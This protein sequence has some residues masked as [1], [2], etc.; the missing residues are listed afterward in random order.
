MSGSVTYMDIKTEIVGRI[1]RGDWP[2]DTI[3]PGEVELAAQLGCARATVN[4][5]LR[6]LADEGVVERRRKAGTR[7]VAGQNRSARID[8][9]V[10]RTQIEAA[11]AHYRYEL[12]KR[13]I[14]AARDP[15]RARLDLQSDQEVLSLECLHFAGD[16]PYQ[17]EVRW[18]NLAAVPAARDEPFEQI[19]PNEWLLRE[20]PLTDAEHVMSAG[21]ATKHQASALH[22]EE[23]DAVFIVERRTWLGAETIT[24]VR[25]VHVGATFQLRS[26]NLQQLETD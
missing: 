15:I 7:V 16:A 25:L 17:L 3:I 2:L 24:W 18:I 22:I 23:R 12:R 1:R 10:I 5:A 26:R 11:G 21:N 6:E 20:K 13:K 8:I 9:P 4:R 19:G 14:V